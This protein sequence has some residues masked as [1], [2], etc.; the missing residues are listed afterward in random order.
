M[1]WEHVGGLKDVRRELVDF[2]ELPRKHPSL[3]RHLPRRVGILLFGPP[4]TG[5]TLIAKALA[6]E[7]GMNF[8]SVK[9]PELLD[10][11]VGESERQVRD[12]FRA[13]VDTSPCVLFFDELDSLAPQRGRG[14]DA[15]GVM[16]RVVSQFLTEM[17][18]LQQ[19]EV[20]VVGAT[21]RPDLLDSALL[22]PGRFD[23]SVFLG[24]PSELEGKV[25]MIKACLKTTPI[26]KQNQ[27]LLSREDWD[28]LANQ[29]QYGCTGADIASAVQEAIKMALETRIGEL[30]RELE[31]L[32]KND[33]NI[34][35]MEYIQS[36]ED[37]NQLKSISIFYEN[38][39]ECLQN[40]RPSVSEQDIKR[41]LSLKDKF[42][43]FG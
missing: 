5:K 30:K 29:L 9:G 19:V 1:R 31:E 10:M 33:Q 2:I 39:S 27:Q 13:A 15:G 11:Y 40:Q 28:H 21:N 14:G 38:L 25:S 7:C 20:F 41:Y 17:D 32:N 24:P 43:N 4:G 37:K 3:F 18:G 23:R 22:R 42:G 12:V 34:S 35:M 6:S 36:L 26:L 16:D 8:L